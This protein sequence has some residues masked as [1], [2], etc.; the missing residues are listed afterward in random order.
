MGSEK[1]GVQ[2]PGPRPQP[3]RAPGAGPH[4]AATHVLHTAIVW[5]ASPVQ[6]SEMVL[7]WRLTWWKNVVAGREE[8]GRA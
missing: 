4:Q 7:Y 2:Q 8:K 5:H 3:A 6:N 1:T